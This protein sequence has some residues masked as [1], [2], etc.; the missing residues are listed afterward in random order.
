[1][2]DLSHEIKVAIGTAYLLSTVGTPWE[3]VDNTGLLLSLMGTATAITGERMPR[4][5]VTNA[6]AHYLKAVDAIRQDHTALEA[7]DICMTV[8]IIVGPMIVNG[9]YGVIDWKKIGAIASHPQQQ[10]A[11]KTEGKQP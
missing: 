1:M 11:T 5:L 4:D 3:R 9:Q 6:R 7:I 2:T 10:P 8:S